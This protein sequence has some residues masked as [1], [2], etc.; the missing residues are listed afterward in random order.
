MIMYP[1]ASLAWLRIGSDLSISPSRFPLGSLFPV[2]PF[3]VL[4]YLLATRI[5]QQSPPAGF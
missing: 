3:E 4:Y 1:S 2:H 5:D